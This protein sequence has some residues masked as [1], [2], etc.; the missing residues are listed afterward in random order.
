MSK[1]KLGCTNNKRCKNGSDL[2]QIQMNL[3]WFGS[4]RKMKRGLHSEKNDRGTLAQNP[5][6]VIYLTPAGENQKWA[7]P[8]L[9]C[10]QEKKMRRGTEPLTSWPRTSV[11]QGKEGEKGGGFALGENRTRV[12]RLTT[13]ARYHCAAC[14]SSTEDR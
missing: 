13:R 14:N 3:N 10:C 5:S 6:R 7:E 1:L 11:S 12:S 8:S 4:N 2:N 9:L